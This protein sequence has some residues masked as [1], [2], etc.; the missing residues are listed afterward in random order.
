M[1]DPARHAMAQIDALREI[2]LKIRSNPEIVDA[3]NGAVFGLANRLKIHPH[4][5]AIYILIRT[6]SLI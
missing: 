3:I 5:L 4:D 2:E 1:I 6:T